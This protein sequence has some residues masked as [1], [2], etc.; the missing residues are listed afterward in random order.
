MTPDQQCWEAVAAVLTGQRLTAPDEP[1]WQPTDVVEWLAGQGWPA[2][3]LVQRRA[4]C[5]Q[6]GRSWPDPLPDDLSTGLE[7]A[8][9]AAVLAQVRRIAGLDGLSATVHRGAVVI[10]PDEA[11]LLAERPPHS[12]LH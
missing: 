12:V 5:Q 3:R 2:S 4:A 8:R 6:E 9:Y 1:G 7:F 10:G 11:R